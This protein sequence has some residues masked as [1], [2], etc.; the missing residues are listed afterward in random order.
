MNTKI[1][2]LGCGWLG[3][4]LGLHLHEKGF[5][6]KGSTTSPEK[7]LTASQSGIEP[8]I[9]AFPRDIDS[10]EGRAF[11]ECEVMVITIPPNLKLKPKNESLSCYIKKLMAR[12]NKSGVSKVVYFSSTA[13]YGEATGL[14]TETSPPNPTSERAAN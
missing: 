1:S 4:P 2:I 8:F 9:I 14:V 10:P 5:Y 12:L 11:F 6:V 7:L 3:Y 13:V